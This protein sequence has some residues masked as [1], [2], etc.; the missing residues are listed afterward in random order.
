VAGSLEEKISDLE[1]SH[2]NHCKW[3]ERVYRS[4]LLQVHFK[5]EDRHANAGN[6]EFVPHGFRGDGVNGHQSRKE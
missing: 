6:V 3:L 2:C 1:N 4:N 5:K